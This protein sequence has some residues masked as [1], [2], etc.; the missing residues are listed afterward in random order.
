MFVSKR[1]L[2]QSQKKLRESDNELRQRQKEIRQ[3]QK[4]IRLQQQKFSSEINKMKLEF[5]QYAR[6][7]KEMII[8][9]YYLRD[10]LNHLLSVFDDCVGFHMDNRFLRQIVI[11]EIRL[12]IND[13]PLQNKTNPILKEEYSNFFY[14]Y[15]Q[16]SLVT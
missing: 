4:E 8:V 3:T 2:A 11:R 13:S 16:N 6:K 12:V 14:Q 9:S 7:S 5:E 15:P 1:K 10:A